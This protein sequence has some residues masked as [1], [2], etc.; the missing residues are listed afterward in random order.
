MRGLNV[1]LSVLVSLVIGL[2]VLEGGLRLLGFGP[3]KNLNRFDPVT[4][5]SKKADARQHK[6]TGE[7]DIVLETNAFGLRDDPMESRAKAPGTLRAVALGDSFTLGYTVDRADLFVDILERWWRAEERRTDVINAGTEGWST[8]QQVAWFLDQGFEYQPDLVLVFAYENDLYWSSETQYPPDLD[9]PRFSADGKLEQRVLEDHAGNRWTDDFALTRLLFKKR[10]AERFFFTPPGG[11]RAIFKEWGA[12]LVEQPEFMADAEART[13]GALRALKARCDELGARVAVVPI[14]SHS[15]VDEAYAAE[16]GEGALGLP[17]EAWSPDKPVETFLRL[18]REVGVEG[19]DVRPALQAA[20]AAG[21]TLYFARDWHFNERGNAVFAT[22]LKGEIDARGWFPSEFAPTRSVAQAPE[23]VHAAGPGGV[24]FALKLFG[25][26]WLALTALYALTY[27]DEPLWQPPLKV[28]ALLA[29]VFTIFLGARWLIALVPPQI[30]PFVMIG[31]IGFVL[32]FV[33]Y[34][35]GHRVATILELMKS[36][37][38]RGHWYLMPLVVVLLTVGSL[39]VVAASSPLVA[40]F[41]YT[42][43]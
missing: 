39:L 22:A 23:H 8:D 15:F 38:L 6:R 32:I 4:G 9:K 24:P 33:A 25:V 42:L 27:R 41:I 3:P 19:I 2:L 16:F 14:P 28:G 12:L 34:K 17:R 37:T 13:A 30:G 21:E 31:L 18:A 11:S 26:L 36:F 29:S 7:F 35:L 5:W 43:F 40:P 20:A 1:F 10:P